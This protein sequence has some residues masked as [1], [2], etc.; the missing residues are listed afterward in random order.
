MKVLVTRFS[1]IGDVALT[2]PVLHA[3]NLHHQDVEVIM[4]SKPQFESIFQPLN[5][6]FIGADLK[7]RHKGLIGLKSLS[8]EII[9]DYAPDKMVDLHDVLRTRILR[10]MFAVHGLK[11]TAIDKGRK[12]KKQ[13][14]RRANKV[15][16]ALPH[17][18]TR[19]Q[20]AFAE[21]GIHIPL[22]LDSPELPEYHSVLADSAWAEMNLS[23]STIGFAPF[24][25]HKGKTWPLAQSED[26]LN[27]MLDAGL[28]VVLFGGPED[29]PVLR[30][31]AA[32]TSNIS[33]VP[34]TLSFGAEIAFMKNLRLMIS[35]DSANMHL[36]ALAKIPVIS[37]WGATHAFAGFSPLGQPS[38]NIIGIS[39]E[40]LDCRPC[41]VY[42]NKDCFRKDYACLNLIT[43]ASVMSKIVT[44]LEQF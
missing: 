9:K 4:L 23:N 29:R 35:M 24:A 31:L 6:T 39:H 13:L 40:E 3:L 7:G 21:A 20:Q 27:K 16:S 11:S 28:Q 37:I 38:D 17:T 43:P 19:Y 22:N 42:G 32:G 14:T 2:I 18:V 34:E 33:L 15:Y 26:L 12:E 8:K 1:S 44:T 10:R 5:V 41:S 25:A 30:D 36:A